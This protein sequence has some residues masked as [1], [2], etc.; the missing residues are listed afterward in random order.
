MLCWGH[1]YGD[2]VTLAWYA[3]QQARPSYKQFLLSKNYYWNGDPDSWELTAEGMERG[4]DPANH[5]CGTPG[6]QRVPPILSQS[7]AL[8]MLRGRGE[9]PPPWLGR[10]RP[11]DFTDNDEFLRVHCVAIYRLLGPW[12]RSPNTYRLLVPLPP[13]VITFVLSSSELFSIRAYSNMSAVSRHCPPCCPFF[14]WPKAY[15]GYLSNH[16]LVESDKKRIVLILF[17]I[18]Y[19]DRDILLGSSVLFE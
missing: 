11:M 13:N 10:D 16:F 15:S 19:W 6:P 1:G 14:A 5:M 7:P 4:F 12:S 3:V 2:T 8:R 9:D 18:A 17:G